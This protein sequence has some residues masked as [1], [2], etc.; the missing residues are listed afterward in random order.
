MDPYAMQQHMQLQQSQ[1]MQQQAKPDGR[2]FPNLGS[3]RQR[4]T[5]GG[6]GGS[7]AGSVGG[8]GAGSN[9]MAAMGLGN[10]PGQ[11]MMLPPQ[12]SGSRH[13]LERQKAAQRR[14]RQEQAMQKVKE[15]KANQPDPSLFSEPVKIN[16]SNDSGGD[17][18]M[19]KQR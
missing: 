6:G 10:G 12:S 11:G 14:A 2:G 1:G 17:S 3:S 8:G 5:S 19:Y 13:A 9:P 15:E 16:S 7:T 4:P 18:G